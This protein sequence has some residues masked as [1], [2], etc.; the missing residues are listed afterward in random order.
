MA[1]SQGGAQLVADERVLGAAQDAA[2][3]RIRERDPSRR[4]GHENA[5]LEAVDE[6]GEAAASLLE[7]GAVLGQPLRHQVERRHELGQVLGLD[8]LDLLAE[9]ALADALDAR[10][11]LAQR[12]GDQVGED[13]GLTAV[14]TVAGAAGSLAASF[15]L[16]LAGLWGSF[17]GIVALYLLI[18]M[19][20]IVQRQQW[21]EVPLLAL[22]AC[23]GLGFTW[24]M[25]QVET[26]LQSGDKLL[27]RWE[28]AYG[29]IDAVELKDG[30]RYVR[31]NLHYG[32]GSSRNSVQRDY[33]QGH[34][35]LLLHGQARDVLFLGMGTGQTAAAALKHEELQSITVVE[36][37]PEA[38][39]AARY[40]KETNRGLVDHPRVEI[41]VNDARRFLR[42]SGR[43]F[44]VIVSDLFV[45]WESHTGYL[46][47]VE[48][49]QAGRASLRPGT[50]GKEPGG[51]FCQWLPLYQMGQAD[52]ELIA[53]SFAEVFPHTT[54]WWVRT[55]ANSPVLGLIGSEQPIVFAQTAA[56]NGYVEHHPH[57]GLQDDWLA[58]G[59]AI[60]SSYIGS[61]PTEK[62]GTSRLL[63]TD[64]HP[65]VEFS[66]PIAHVDNR[67]LR[68]GRMRTYFQEVL[69][70]L[71]QT[72]LVVD[73]FA[74]QATNHAWRL[75]EQ[76][77]LLGIEE[78]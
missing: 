12:L 25:L 67:K 68:G 71:P 51:L 44:D 66:A 32:F 52:F 73:G 21:W 7:L 18:A 45:P 43:Q 54:L 26:T 38:V 8:A 70:Q 13:S 17:A 49:Y 19:A 23:L 24:D 29:W 76:R 59:N 78:K 61:L 63:N 1:R 77:R 20:V 3:G 6:H 5:V 9:L 31:Q 37:I 58:D 27:R 40:L 50:P 36:L 64:E 53:N 42:G 74:G 46:Y 39:E 15:L 47:T 72:G 69:S 16:P 14:S 60:L 75:A 65:R 4:V 62:L 22:L 41:Q 56:A 48:H 34:L 2:G 11:Q 28:S 33:R 57:S 35:P 10:R 30:S 55:N